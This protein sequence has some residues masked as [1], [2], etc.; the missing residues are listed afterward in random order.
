MYISKKCIIVVANFLRISNS[1]FCSSS[2][3][4][5]SREIVVGSL[6][7]VYSIIDYL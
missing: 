7:A 1:Q 2:C 5:T 3:S 4:N 6:E